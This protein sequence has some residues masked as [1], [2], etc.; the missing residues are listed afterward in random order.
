MIFLI[1]PRHSSG[2]HD[3]RAPLEWRGPMKGFFQEGGIS[4]LA[5]SRPEIL[6][7]SAYNRSTSEWTLV[8]SVDSAKG[9]STKS[10]V[11]LGLL[12]LFPGRLDAGGAHAVGH[13]LGALDVLLQRVPGALGVLHVA[14]PGAHAQHLLDRLEVLEGAAQLELSDHGMAQGLECLVLIGAE[15]ARLA[16]DHAQRAERM[17]VR[18]RQRRAGVEADVRRLRDERV[19]GETAIARGVLHDHD[20]VVEDRVGAESDV[21]RCL[22]S[23]DADIRLE[24]Q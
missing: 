11:A 4:G 22:R 6:V 14:A 19:A 1:G 3:S 8:D 10:S 5:D 17:A 21:E 2:A 9:D 23:V 18:H 24:P 7:P 15:M 12:P 13:G 20:L 16:V